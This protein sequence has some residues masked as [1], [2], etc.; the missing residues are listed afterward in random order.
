MN[1]KIKRLAAPGVRFF[2]FVLVAFAA[3]TFFIHRTL[4]YIEAGCIVALVIYYII[5][6]R[7]QRRM[8]LKYIEDVTY[9]TENAKNNT[10][11]N[12]PL[13]MVV[14]KMD[15]YNIVW[16][17]KIFFML[18]G[19]EQ[20]KYDANLTEMV[21][22]FNNKW[23]YEGKS[24][25]PGI[26]QVE[27]RKYQLHGNV[28]RGKGEENNR[29]DEKGF[30]G[31]TYWVD[32]TDFDNIRKEYENSRPVVMLLVV[33]NYEELMKPVAERDRTELRGTLDD[34]ILGWCDGRGGLSRSIDRD[35]YLFLF[36]NRHLQEIIDGNF[37]ILEKIHETVSGGINASLSI[38]IGIGGKSFEEDYSFANLAIDMA[39]SR[40][41]DQ[42]VIKNK[43]NFEFFGGMGEEVESR[44]KV[45]SRVTA[46]AFGSLI[47]DADKVFVMGHSYSDLDCIGAA[48]GVKRIAEF[49]E[50]PCYVIVDES[51]T[52]AGEFIAYLKSN[53]GYENIF[54]SPD[55]AMLSLDSK[56]LL[57]V[58]DTNR[59]EQVESRQVLESCNRIAVIDHHRR[60]ASYIQNVALSYH[61]T[62][63]SSAS[64]LVCEL[65]VLLL[66]KNAMS[67]IESEALLA[68]I[69]L[70]TKNFTIR[71]RQ[72]TFDMASVLRKAGADPSVVK[73]YLQTNMADSV[74][75][76]KILQS[77][78]LYKSK[79]AIAVSDE[80]QTR[81]ISSQAADEL[82]NISGVEASI[83]LYATN[84][85]GVNISARSIG[86]VNVQLILERLGGGGNKSVAGA[87]VSNI[88]LRTAFNKVCAVIDELYE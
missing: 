85:G 35:R 27:G 38:G 79:I 74:S 3:V 37:D 9:D 73:K 58:V 60:A 1:N 20:P 8:L 69:I 2:F 11:M 75:K 87:Q 13:P 57:V 62:A 40:G 26:V 72:I 81:I 77:A 41:G 86:N 55:D 84:E 42:A 28:I 76:Y 66:D 48:V 56:S 31:I 43:Y 25:Y 59:P 19:K 78:R 4:A 45:K 64:E 5:L 44:S 70:D 7:K 17:N 12:F 53:P 88:D 30:M 22:G 54:I 15:D 34:V 49:F 36:E 18:F 21:P 24:A 67:K 63:A 65:I 50:K 51:T 46:N 52:S 47:K 16:A 80:E 33:D 14:F 82:L 10:L 32:I 29:P 61:Q 83:V 68:G 39:L 71:T 23:L 6:T